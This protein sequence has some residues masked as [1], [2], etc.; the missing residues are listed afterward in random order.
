MINTEEKIHLVFDDG[1]SNKEYNVNLKQKDN[2]WEVVCT[3]GKRYYP[4][5][6]A[7][8]TK[9]VVS[10]HEAKEAYDKIVAQKTRK[11]YEPA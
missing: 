4:N 11:G 5:C 10:Y 6:V 1:W 9:G 7:I 3:Y 8:K 2:G